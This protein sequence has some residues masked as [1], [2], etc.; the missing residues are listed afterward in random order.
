M[1]KLFF[2]LV[3]ASGMLVAQTPNA[4]NTQAIGKFLKLSKVPSG[5]ENDNVLV[6]GTDGIV[7][8]VPR[9]EFG[10]GSQ[11]NA[12]WNATSGAAM[13]LN[14]PIIPTVVPQVNA[15]WNATS[16]VTQ[17]LNKPVISTSG[18]SLSGNTAGSTGF[19][20]TTDNQ[21]IR[22]KV[23]NEPAG[24]ISAYGNQGSVF[25]GVHAGLSEFVDSN[26]N[27]AIG[28]LALRESNR[29]MSNTAIGFNSLRNFK[30]TYYGDNT[31]VGSFSGNSITTGIHNTVIGSNS[32]GITTGSGNTIIGAY[33]RTPN[34]TDNN[35]IVLA[36]GGSIPVPGGADTP[37]ITR[38]SFNGTNWT[39]AGQINKSSLD[40][41]PASATA[42]GTVGEIRITATHVYW[43]I[44]T[45]TWI[46]AAGT[47][48]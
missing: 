16:G 24:G 27:V 10:G 14:K 43:C 20:G 33:A 34:L 46:R 12:D 37:G 13:I 36:S 22:L 21:P 6:R 19:F 18:W 41:A 1:R 31:A 35:Y 3:L 8:S 32:G 48:W 4:T 2:L 38:A 29:G 30:K 42:P 5:L 39:F 26:Y 25:I 9:S 40:T 11:V 28:Q 17:I 7:K 47:T 45:N 23:G 15:D 44:A